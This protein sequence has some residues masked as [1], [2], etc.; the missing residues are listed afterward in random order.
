MK[1]VL[2][3][4]AL[5]LPTSVGALDITAVAPASASPGSIVSLSGGP[6]AEG[7][8][9]RLGE[10]ELAVLQRQPRQ[11]HFEVPSWPPGDYLLSLG[12]NGRSYKSPFIFR[13]TPAQ[14]SLSAISPSVIDVCTT[15][16]ERQISITG[17]H[18]GLQP[19]VLLNEAAVPLTAVR[20]GEIIVTLP[21]LEAGIYSLQVVSAAGVPSVAQLLT[22]N[23]QPRI[24]MVTEGKDDVVS[25]ELVLTGSNFSPRT[26]LL[27]D[28][29]P[30]AVPST[31]ATAPARPDILPGV[32]FL[33]FL[34]C[35]TLV[36]TRFPFSRELR[37][38]SLQVANPDGSS[39]DPYPVTIP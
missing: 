10:E 18:F 6:F 5:L 22:V 33:R 4:F 20:P 15:P 12:Q 8:T 34:D 2:L 35:R 3:L 30:V 32:D 7:V 37:G 14:A 21:P 11:L 24:E 13:I 25:Y 39:S 29:L 17:E 1:C 28:G 16:S 19:Q 36:Y 38:I 23:G 26:L 31:S 27:V 9:V